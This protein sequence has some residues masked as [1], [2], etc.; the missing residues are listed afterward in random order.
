MKPAYSIEVVFAE[1][2]L[3]EADQVFTTD[4]VVRTNS[5]PRNPN[6]HCINPIRGPVLQVHSLVACG[7]QLA[8]K[9]IFTTIEGD[10]EEPTVQVIR[11]FYRLP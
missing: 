9:H 4:I 10:D 2:S 8:Y 11:V 3:F 6:D 5:L 1:D 7:A